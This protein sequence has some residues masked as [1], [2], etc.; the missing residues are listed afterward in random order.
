M[1]PEA[2]ITMLQFADGLFP[3]G[4]YA[5][6]FG[7]EAYVARGIVSHAG[8]VEQLLRA[9]LQGSAG[10]TDAVAIVCALRATSLKDLDRCLELDSLIDAMKPALEL[11]NASRQMG[12]QTARIADALLEHPILREFARLASADITPCHHSVV[13]GIAGG[14]QGWPPFETAAAYLYSSTAAIVG[15][16]LRLIPLGQLKGQLIIRS[17]TPLIG[18]LASEA[19]AK[20]VHEIAGFVPALEIASMRHAAMD[21]RLFRS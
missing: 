8:D 13:F 6:S 4:A 5:H 20:G 12:R 16:A 2:T 19:T 3:A 14:A 21:A 18:R 1:N 17:L 7:L 10:P 11:R 9:Y 15:A